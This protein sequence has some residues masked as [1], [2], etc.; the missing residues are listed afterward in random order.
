MLTLDEALG[1][2]GD[3]A[4]RPHVWTDAEKTGVEAEPAEEAAEEAAE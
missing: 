4:G 2:V 1:L 3:V